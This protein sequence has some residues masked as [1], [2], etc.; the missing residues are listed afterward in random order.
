MTRQLLELSLPTDYTEDDLRIMIR[1]ET[2]LS[3]FSYKIDL[4]SLDAR[5]KDRIHWNLRVW[6]SDNEEEILATQEGERMIIPDVA[7]KRAA[8]A[9][10]GPAGFFAGYVL[11]LAGFEVTI[12]EKGPEANK[13]YEDIRKFETTGVFTPYS[14]YAHGEGG[15]GTFSDGKLTSRTKNISKEKRF[16]IES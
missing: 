13:R 8:I 16:L 4:K 14:N 10:S 11:A 12:F 9:G 3:G 6:V 2:G 5:K 1:K 7:K 15:A